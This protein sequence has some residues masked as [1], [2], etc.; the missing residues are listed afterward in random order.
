MPTRKQIE[1]LIKNS[2]SDV[3]YPGEGHLID[4][5]EGEEPKYLAQEFKGKK[6][7]RKLDSKFIDLAPQGFSTALSFFSDEAFRFYLPAY[8]IADLRGRL[9]NTDVLFH[10]CHGLDD[11]SKNRKVNPR[12]YGDR[13]RFHERIY[14]FTMFNSRQVRAI[15]QF[16]K[17]KI[18]WPDLLEVDVLKVEQALR[19]Y[20]ERREICIKEFAECL[21]SPEKSANTDPGPV[22]AG[23]KMATKR[24]IEKHIREAFANA[25]PPLPW[26]I[27]G[28]Q[29]GVESKNLTQE[30]LE[31]KNWRK[32]D[33]KFLDQAPRGLS[34]ALSLFSD[35]AI[36]FY[37]PAYLIADLRGELKKA[38][39][40]GHL[41]HGFGDADKDRKI[42]PKRFGERTWFHGS[43]YRFAVFGKEQARAIV[44]FL[45]CKHGLPN[46]PETVKESIE[47]ALRNYWGSR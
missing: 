4:S 33:A 11:A 39:V 13:T 18:R 30:F 40:I 25:R 24:Q 22:T 5:L 7:W 16:I 3:E 20:W 6:D 37:L 47:Q 27:A 36:R 29:E 26:C 34:T 9:K 15:I 46:L 19:N 31:K 2:F 32:L 45:R 43:Q 35:E 44:E 21:E 41:C 1:E 28:G 38:D 14:K 12:R 23:G 17:Y 10:L 8:L 42:D